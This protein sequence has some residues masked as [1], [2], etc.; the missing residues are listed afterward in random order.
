MDPT[1]V[2]VISFATATV[3]PPLGPVAPSTLG[4]RRS[5]LSQLIDPADETE[6]EI[7]SSRQVDAAYRMLTLVKGA[8]P[9]EEAEPSPEQITALHHRTVEVG[10]DPYGDSGLLID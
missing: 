1:D 5:K 10:A 4:K 9:Q 8:L 6:L 7:L 3:T 2:T